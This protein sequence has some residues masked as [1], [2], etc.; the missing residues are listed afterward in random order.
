MPTLLRCLLLLSVLGLA[1]CGSGTR[2]EPREVQGYAAMVDEGGQPR[3]WLLTR[4]EETRES[5]NP[6]RRGPSQRKLVLVHF[7][8]H[9]FDPQSARPLWTRRV[10]SF[11]AQDGVIAPIVGGTVRGRLLGQD[12]DRVWLVI[13]RDPRALDVADGAQVD[14]AERIVQRHPSLAGMLPEDP[15]RY[16]FDRGLVF[17]AADASQYVLQGPEGALAPYVPPPAPVQ[18]TGHEAAKTPLRPYGDVPLRLLEFEGRWLGLYTAAEAEDAATDP[19]GRHLAFPY[20]VIDQGA[21]ARRGL[22]SGT[23]EE[24]QQFDERF[25]RFTAMTPV[26]GSPVFLRGRFVRQ[27]GRD[28]ALVPPGE[29]GLL[30]WHNTRID[31]EGRLAMTRLDAALAPAWTA[32][33]PLSDSPSNA[34]LSTRTW[35]VGDRIIAVGEL[36]TT[37]GERVLREVHVVSV[38]AGTGQFAAW[39]V[40]QGAPP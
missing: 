25:P 28:E 3:L 17:M 9:A 30:V 14:D 36:A 18:A 26:A 19:F 22:W 33:L 7:D 11:K 10:Y 2:L 23:V 35:A 24:V 1:S 37:K 32:E 34:H 12:G 38:D 20:T 21:L 16:G 27:P 31:R 39:N 40:Q 8:L 29:P 6:T 13:G 4:Q 5:R 15:Q